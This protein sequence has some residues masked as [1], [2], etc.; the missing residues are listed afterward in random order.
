M[1]F[2]QDDRIVRL[3]NVG[4]IVF[5][6]TENRDEGIFQCFADNGYGISVSDKIHFKEAKLMDFKYERRLVVY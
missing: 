4:T 3:P 1:P 6:I 2:V 5:N